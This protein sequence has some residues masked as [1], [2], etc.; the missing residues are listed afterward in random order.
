LA[1]IAPAE[2]AL[3]GLRGAVNLKGAF[4]WL[5]KQA[6]TAEIVMPKTILITAYSN[7]R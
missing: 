2:W 3:F 6:S 4:N 1:P 5:P 7:A